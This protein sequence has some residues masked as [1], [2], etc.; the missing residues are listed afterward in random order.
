MEGCIECGRRRP[1]ATRNVG[2]GSTRNAIRDARQ[3]LVPLTVG[4]QW[5]MSTAS[6]HVAEGLCI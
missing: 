4:V 1:E 5:E 3:M 2:S 6:E